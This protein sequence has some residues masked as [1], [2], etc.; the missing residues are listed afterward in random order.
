[1][2]VAQTF[3]ID[4]NS[5]GGAGQ[6]N[7][8]SVDL[9]FKQKPYKIGNISGVVDPGINVYIVPTSAGGI[10][11]YTNLD[12][13]TN[14]RKEYS[15]IVSSIDASQVTKFRFSKP[16]TVKTGQEYAIVVKSDSK[17][18][19]ELWAAT[20]GETNVSDK[21]TSVGLAGKYIGRYFELSTA[22][23]T[24]QPLPYKS[25]KFAVYVAK[26]SGAQPIVNLYINN[27]EYVTYNEIQSTGT[28]K[29]GEYVFQDKTTPDGTASVTKGQNYITT[30][31][32]AF[33]S[34]SAS[35][36][37]CYIVIKDYKNL[38]VRKVINVSSDN[39]TITV[40]TPF[41][42]TN[43]SVSFIKSPV[44]TAYITKRS[45]TINDNDNLIVLA[46]STANSTL[47]FSNNSILRG[48]QSGAVISNAYFNDILVHY[49]EPHVYVHTPSG[50]SFDTK[51]IF[52]YTS[53]DDVNGINFSGGE[54]N[55][56][57]SM[58][59]PT[60]LDVGTPVMLK[61][62]T[63][64]VVYNS[65]SAANNSLSSR[66]QITMTNNNDYVSPQ[67]D[68]NATDV[69][70]TRYIIN[71]DATGENTNNGNAY[72]KHIT[73]KVNFG[74]NRQAEDILI[75]LDAY[76]PSGTDIQVYTKL[77][78]SNDSDYFD[79][80]DWTLL[81]EISGNR[82]SSMTDLNDYVE[83]NYG[84]YPYPPTLNTLSGSVSVS[85]GNTIVIG[86]GTQFNNNVTV[87]NFTINGNS[88]S[89]TTNNSI[90]G[91]G[92]ANGMLVT[93]TGI[94]DQT[95]VTAFYTANS[96][97]ILSK[98]ANYYSSGTTLTFSQV[99]SGGLIAGDLVKIYPP[100]F[101]NNYIIVPVASVSNN[102]YLTLTT[103]ISSSDV[104]RVGSSALSIDKLAYPNQAF[105]NL[106]NNNVVRYFNSNLAR[107]DK[108]DTFALK[109]VFLSNSQFLIPK[110]KDIRAI[111]VSA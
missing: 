3:T 110:I 56:P 55:F 74:D 97:V 100:L 65:L 41:S 39:N 11:N 58:Y 21:T 80:K 81:Q 94:P 63:N 30:S 23:A 105:T 79:D 77:Y 31:G 28:L 15:E 13:F 62:R 103:A 46:N 53:T 70:F 1:M 24:W 6:V 88:P 96:T 93:G 54:L 20:Q 102:T 47:H 8:S 76:K 85:S 108:Y 67:I 38:N 10:P 5:V 12:D 66:L 32:G 34:F 92:L 87:T 51:Q 26:Y 2:L 48:E 52:K 78:N 9:Y 99:G 22:A 14:S 64:E 19:F 83:Y 59:S 25:L 84:L 40:D 75:Y 101:P 17:E 71:N 72:S 68:F 50:T 86:T 43:T 82:N 16:I 18:A 7:I 42:V 98:N 89:I 4:L 27:Y 37:P 44:A 109:I 61:S 90:T 35:G 45:K 106:A 49:S 104:S 91:I 36:D 60:T 95:Y 33:S 29:G 111:G 73:T 107:F 69:F 57:V